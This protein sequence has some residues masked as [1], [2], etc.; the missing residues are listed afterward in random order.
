[1]TN[2]STVC[3]MITIVVY[4][5]GMLLVGVYFTKKNNSTSD[6]YLGGRTLGPLVT[7]MSAEASDMSSYLLMGASGA[8]LFIGACRGRLDGYGLAAGTYLN[9]LF[10]IEKAAP[11]HAHFRRNHA[12]GIFLKALPR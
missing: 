3:I 8:G 11:L 10:I 7:A 4:L 1:M 2:S 5:I 6:F 12:A 9:W